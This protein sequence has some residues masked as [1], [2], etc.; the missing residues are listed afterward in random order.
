MY[1]NPL[2]LKTR[3][4]LEKLDDTGTLYKVKGTW[5][6]VVVTMKL[7][8]VSLPLNLADWHSFPNTAHIINT[9]LSNTWLLVLNDTKA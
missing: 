1:A 6:T 4:V 9:C 3:K 5:L 7:M 2:V 8:A